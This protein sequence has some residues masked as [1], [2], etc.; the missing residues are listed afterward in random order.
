MLINIFSTNFFIRTKKAATAR[1]KLSAERVAPIIFCRYSPNPL[2]INPVVCI[3]Q[4]PSRNN[5][6]RPQGGDSRPALP[7]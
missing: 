7:H 6:T 5:I 1:R 4:S 3:A 2:R